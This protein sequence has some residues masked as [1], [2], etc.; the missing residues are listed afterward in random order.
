MFNFNDGDIIYWCHELYRIRRD[1]GD[2]GDVE[3]LD[4][5]FVASNFYYNYS[6]E[7][8]VLVASAIEI[9]DLTYDQLIDYLR[10]LRNKVYFSK[11]INKILMDLK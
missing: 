10:G 4:G 6:G 5:E 11:N 7:K 2:R 1:S 3:Y 9:K 8:A